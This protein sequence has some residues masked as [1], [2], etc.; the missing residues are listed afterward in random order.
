MRN[1]GPVTQAEYVLPEDEVIITHT[2]RSSR[3]TYA[4]PAFFASSQFSLEECMGQPQNIVR[5]PDMPREAFADMWATIGTGRSWSGIVKNRRKDGG[6]YWVRA[7]VTPMVEDGGRIV[8]Y[9]SVR[10]QADARRDCTGRARVCR[11]IRNGRAHNIQIDRGRI[12]DVSIAGRL[13]RLVTHLSLERGSGS[14]W[15]RSWRCSPPF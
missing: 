10:T 4:N 8:G 7:N 14:C 5:H 6:F 15:A 11:C 1:N 3:I 2:D 13:G 9:M 12:R